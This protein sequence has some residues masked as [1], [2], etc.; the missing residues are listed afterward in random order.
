MVLY[1]QMCTHTCIYG[2][3]HTCVPTS[4]L[5]VRVRLQFS[6]DANAPK[7][8]P[9]QY[10]QV[11]TSSSPLQKAQQRSSAQGGGVAGD[12]E[13]KAAPDLENP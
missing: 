7:T 2:N 3:M 12:S 10:S 9:W 1:V 13:K 5:G 8:H 4:D 11:T 6:D